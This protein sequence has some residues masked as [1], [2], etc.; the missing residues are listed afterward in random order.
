MDNKACK[1][2]CIGTYLIFKAPKM[3][4]KPGFY[5]KMALKLSNHLHKWRK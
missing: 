5:M 1:S 4:F 3:I 2:R